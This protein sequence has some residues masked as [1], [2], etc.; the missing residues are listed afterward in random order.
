MFNAIT[1]NIADC[2][3]PNQIWPR[4]IGANVYYTLQEYEKAIADCEA[5]IQIDANFTKVS[6]QEP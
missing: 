2:F 5:A 6:G 1:D 4:H 3:F